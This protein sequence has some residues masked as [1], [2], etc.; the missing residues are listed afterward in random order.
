[1][2]KVWT[3]LAG[4]VL[5]SALCLPARALTGQEV[6][7]R[8]EA[9]I[10]VEGLQRA[11]A[12]SGGEAQYGASLDE[13]LEALLDTGTRELGVRCAPRPGPGRCCW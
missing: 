9:L 8:Q 10:D 6:L 4:L 7:E 1:M 11:A 13:G 5:A 2:E 12:E 3:V